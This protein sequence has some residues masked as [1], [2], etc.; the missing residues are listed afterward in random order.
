MSAPKPR[1]I[2]WFE[3]GF[4]VVPAM[5][6]LARILELAAAESADWVVLRRAVDWQ[7]KP[8]LYVYRLGELEAL[9]RKAPALAHVAAEDALELREAKASAESSDRKRPAS[10]P[11]GDAHWPSAQR[12]VHA[13]L[14][15]R[16]D[17]IGEIAPDQ[18]PGR[19]PTRGG[20][21][22][23][24]RGGE[25]GAPAAPSPG[26]GGVIGGAA[27]GVAVG[28]GNVRF[29]TV[30]SRS[31]ALRGPQERWR[32]G[33]GRRHGGHRALRAGPG[34]DQGRRR[35]RHRHPGRARRR[36]AG[37]RECPSRRRQGR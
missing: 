6:T 31:D 13:G 24:T 26:G 27:G 22:G 8:L 23:T 15:E 19:G 25:P 7:P 14:D 28:E 3:S 32:C 9:R 1:P 35:G 33:A 18:K 11:P 4:I 17:A 37:A 36:R 20:P 2:R 30:R 10:A 5:R 16:P 12:I 29:E 34:G 21:S